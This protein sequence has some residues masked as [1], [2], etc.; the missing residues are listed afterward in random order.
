VTDAVVVGSG[1]NGLA[2]AL[3][4]AAEGLDV[5]VLEAA[6]TLGGGTRSSELTL[7]GLLHDECSAAHPLAVD[8]PFSRRFDLGA[9]GLRWRWPEVQYSHPL[10]GGGGAA[11]YRSVEQ[12][13]AG[14][15]RDGKYWRAVFGSLSAR[16][17]DIVE[18]ITQPM[19]HRPRHPLT[20]GWF[21]ALSGMPAAVLARLWS[22]PQA[23]AL[24]A[25]VAAHAFRPFVA[26]MSSAVGVT[27]GT[28]AHRFGWPVA[29]GGSQ[30]ISRAMIALAAEHGARFETGVRVS[31]LDQLGTP[32]VVM[33]DLAPAAAARLCADRMPARVSRAL[34]RFRH[35]PGTFKVEFA[36]EGGVPWTH[37]ASRLAGT[38]H[39]GGAYAEIAAAERRTCRGEMAE[40]PFVLVCQQYL[41]DPSR[42]DGDRHPLYA[43]AHVPS[44]WTGDATAQIEA[45]IERFAPGF[46]ERILA[47]H[48]RGPREMQQHNANYVGGDVVTGSNDPL[49]M[50]FRP[51]PALNPYSLGIPGV[52]ICSAATPPGAGAHGMCGYNAA[53]AALRAIGRGDRSASPEAERPSPRERATV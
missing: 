39:V 4:L 23:Q 24:F 8:T 52:Y 34:M 53:N 38:V 28:A 40:R 5:V 14:L 49:Q 37:E 6:D 46:R 44:G 17:G 43:Y 45:Q 9:H 22:R 36:V 10:D 41:A 51:R 3:T 1:P 33:L 30:A 7:P 15:G 27:L 48:V 18:E 12:T 47:R 26:P 2:A 29:E 11:A 32:D 19:L 16:F 31:S 20:M 50:V 42:S 13:A 25:G 35:G 21:G